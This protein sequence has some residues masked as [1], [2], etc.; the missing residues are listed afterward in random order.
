[1]KKPSFCPLKGRDDPRCGREFNCVDCELAANRVMTGDF[2]GRKGNLP[3]IRDDDRPIPVTI[4]EDGR[5]S[6]WEEYLASVRKRNKE[7]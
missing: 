7:K 1:M 4:H 2:D 6:E 3:A 5:D